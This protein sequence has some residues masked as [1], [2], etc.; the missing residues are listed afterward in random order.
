VRTS[1][2]APL[3][4]PDYTPAKGQEN[5]QFYGTDLGYTVSHR[6]ELRI[7]FGD[8][9]A[10]PAPALLF[11]DDAQGTLAFNRC[12]AGN[13]VDAW[14]ATHPLNPNAVWWK[15]S[16][17]PL[18]FVTSAQDQL[19]F[20]QVDNHGTPLSMSAIQ[21]PIGAFSDGRSHAFT[22]FNRSDFAFCGADGSDAS[23]GSGLVCDHA[24]GACLGFGLPV[25]CVLGATTPDTGGC[26]D[27]SAC[28]E[29]GGYCRDPNSSIDDGGVAGKLLS[30]AQVL[31]I[32]VADA[33]HAEQYH[34]TAWNT[35]K[36]LNL[37]LRTIDNWNALRPSANDYSPA[38]GSDPRREK[39]LIWGRPGFVGNQ[40]AGREVQLYFA[41]ADMPQ[42][43]D[44]G[45]PSWS[46][47]YFA[48]VNARGVPQFSSDQADA[49]ALDLSGGHGNPHES[50]DIADQMTVSFVPQLGKWVMLYGGDLDPFV[51]QFYN[52]GAVRDPDGA[53][54]IRFADQ[55]WGPWSPPQ[56][57]F[58]A[59]DPANP[60]AP[61]SQYAEGGVLFHPACTGANCVHG[62]PPDFVL[63]GATPFGYLYGPNII[64][65][66]T[67]SRALGQ[68]DLYWN[69]STT[70]PYQVVLMKTRLSRARAR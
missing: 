47:R 42:V 62:D 6:G 51:A 38:D 67:E 28:T 60:G 17:P 22:A 4:G 8:S 16:G 1:V 31:Q 26:F 55:P 14:V 9:F 2:L 19:G 34:S 46:P 18:T 29:I 56:P 37:A 25:P 20:I 24:L 68:V 7:L 23:C 48:G 52:P 54:Q 3:A 45:V 13:Q 30:V 43:G 12:P 21:T 66:W 65:C 59:G 70:N 49:A 36:F 57:V 58:R 69:V 32:G 5:L 33:A 39:V 40:A 11:D 27:G 44:D 41:I 63:R 10:R 61:G 53:I 64:E 35:N 15:R 50:F